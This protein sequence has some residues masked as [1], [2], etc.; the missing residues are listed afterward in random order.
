MAPQEEAG[1]KC[2]DSFDDLPGLHVDHAD[3]ALVLLADLLHAGWNL[4]VKM[5]TGRLAMTTRLVFVAGA[6]S[7]AAIPLLP[8]PA[9]ASWPYLA[10]GVAALPGALVLKEPFG[11]KRIAAAAAVACGLILLR[12]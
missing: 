2:R 4:L 3:D 7:L 1:P 12:L 8:V 10:V 6:I 11:A 9:R 5:S